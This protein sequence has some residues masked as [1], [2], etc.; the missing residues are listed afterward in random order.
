[1]P[2]LGGTLLQNARRVPDRETIVDR[3][4]RF[5]WAGLAEAA[6]EVAGVL[7][8]LGLRPGH[9]L[10]VLAPNSA[11]HV[12][13]QYAALLL[14]AVVVPLNARFA[15]PEI[16]VVLQDSDASLVVVDRG[17][18]LPAGVTV[19]SV[20]LTELVHGAL[21]ET[22]RPIP[23]DRAEPRGD[24]YLTYTSG[25]TGRPKGV[26]V[27]HDRAIWAGL[28]QVTSLGMSDGERYLHLSPFHHS[29]GVVFLSAVT[30]LGGTHVIGPPFEP[31]AVLKVL[32]E[33]QIQTFLGVPTM[34]QQLLRH[35]DIE[36]RDLSRL[37]RAVFGAAAMPESALREL[38]ARFPTVEFSQ[39]C[40]QTEAGPTG[41]FSTTTQLRERPDATGHQPQPFLE[42]R[43]VTVDGR[44]AA[45]GE[46]GELLFRGPAVMKRY[47]NAPEA[48]AE[49][50]R[51]GWL[52]T[53][54]LFRVDPDGALV[55]VDRLKDL[56]ITGGQNVY[57]AEG[58]QA[59]AG[60]P[61]VGDCAVLGRPHPEWGATVVAVV[62]PLPGETVTLDELR[63]HCATRLS[64]Y[65][66]PRDLVLA[67]IP[68]NAS[69][70]AQKHLLRAAV[71]G[72]EEGAPP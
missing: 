56:I 2:T 46:I 65:K 23:D 27:D 67:T 7:E 5:T 62:D 61:A 55:L 69:G 13:A 66:V 33:E 31:G 51:D 19:R 68:R 48:T 29:G 3:D 37:R 64:S 49:T 12:I 17:D 50:L 71:A 30:L 63:E 60:H 24:A 58:E 11:E 21:A 8:A 52:H 15:A 10:A 57:S 26:L 42:H 44:D 20:S 39:L 54:D 36:R 34:Y 6:L 22:T 28:S 35:P 47:W 59:V 40:G 4:R 18:R 43:I 16:E 41:L 9:R 14:G 25:T 53:G 70:K 1:M 72:R 32:D 38:L 45:P